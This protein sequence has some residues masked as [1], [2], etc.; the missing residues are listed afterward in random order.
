MYIVGI[1]E[2]GRGSIAGPLVVGAVVLDVDIKGMRDSKLLSHAQREKFSDQIYESA[3]YVG[4]GWV[5]AAELDRIG[6]TAALTLAST[7][8]LSELKLSPLTYILDGNFNYLIKA[9]KPYQLVVKGDNSVPSISAAS[10]VAKVARDAYMYKLALELPQYGFERHVGYA[11]K[12]HL[13]ALSSHGVTT[14]H[15]RSFEP[16]KSLVSSA[17]DNSV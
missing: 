17:S 2:V 1:D 6:L 9:Y 16:V 7:R 12:A 15:R 5:S 10:I 8:A 3:K 4:L 11:T 13:E 14:H